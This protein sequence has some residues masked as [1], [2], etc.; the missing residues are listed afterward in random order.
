MNKHE[1][2]QVTQLIIRIDPQ[3]KIRFQIVAL[4]EGTTMS[5]LIRQYI[6]VLVAKLDKK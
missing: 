4:Q 2:D 1:E 6:E 3:L 5:A